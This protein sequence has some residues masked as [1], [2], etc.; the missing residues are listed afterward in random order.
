MK[1]PQ[2][3]LTS[4]FNRFLVYSFF[5][6][7]FYRLTLSQ[8]EISWT[9]IWRNLLFSN[10]RTILM[11]PTCHKIIFNVRLIKYWRKLLNNKEIKTKF[12]VALRKFYRAKSLK[13]RISHLQF[14]KC[15]TSVIRFYNALV[16]QSG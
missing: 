2:H 13:N 4:L 16:F 1:I 3:L 15:N 12:Q 8:L 7:N 11:Q 14:A 5:L 6:S 9:V 10:N